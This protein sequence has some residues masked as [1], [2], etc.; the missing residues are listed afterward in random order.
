MSLP[1]A[2]PELSTLL[3]PTEEQE[4]SCPFLKHWKRDSV[5]YTLSVTKLGEKFDGLINS[6]SS[7]SR[8]RAKTLRWFADYLKAESTSPKLLPFIKEYQEQLHFTVWEHTEATTVK[9]AAWKKLSSKLGQLVDK[10]VTAAKNKYQ[11]A[12][13]SPTPD[14]NEQIFPPDSRFSYRQPGVALLVDTLLELEKKSLS[15]EVPKS[16]GP[17]DWLPGH[18]WVL[19][20]MNSN[21]NSVVGLPPGL[22][23]R[24]RIEKIANGCG[25]I[26]PHPHLAAHV[27]I[28]KSFAAG[29]RNA[30]AVVLRSETNLINYDFRWSLTVAEP[31]ET[32]FHGLALPLKQWLVR[33]ALD[34]ESATLAFALA[35]KSVM[36]GERLRQDLAAT[37]CFRDTSIADEK[38]GWGLIQNNA[39]PSLYQVGGLS[40]KAE[41]VELCKHKRIKAFVIEKEQTSDRPF[42]MGSIQESSFESAYRSFTEHEKILEDHAKLVA[43]HWPEMTVKPDLSNRDDLY[44]KRERL[45]LHVWP[46]LTWEVSNPS[47]K[48]DEDAWVRT[49]VGGTDH[50]QVKSVF[51]KLRDPNRRRHLVVHDG[52]GSGKTVLSLL[53]QHHATNL[54]LRQDLFGDG[55]PRLV[56]RY[57]K[58]LV[59]LDEFESPTLEQILAA[60]PDLVD[61]ANKQKDGAHAFTPI[62]VINYA[63][64]QNRVVIMIDGYDEFT[65]PDKNKLRY[66]F[67]TRSS[68]HKSA[69]DPNNVLWIVL[70]REH[71]IDAEQKVL[72]NVF[73]KFNCFSRLRIELFAKGQ[74]DEVVERAFPDLNGRN[75]RN[76]MMPDLTDEEQNSLLG[77]PHTLNQ[78]I[79]LITEHRRTNR[80]SLP[81]FESQSDLFLQTEKPMLERALSKRNP[82]ESAK[83]SQYGNDKKLY[84]VLEIALSCL[85]FEIAVNRV[86]RS[87]DRNQA[88]KV[89]NAALARFEGIVLNFDRAYAMKHGTAILF[90]W[91]YERLGT[92]ATSN[93]GPN[94]AIGEMIIAFRTNRV[95]ENYVARFLTK[96]AMAEDIADTRKFIGD[97]AWENIWR[98]SIQMPLKDRK[99]KADQAKYAAATRLL[100]ERPQ[101]NE[102]RR[103]TELMYLAEQWLETRDLNVG[104]PSSSLKARY[105]LDLQE[106]FAA[107]R[108]SGTKVHAELWEM[109]NYADIPAGKLE[110]TDGELNCSKIAAFRLCKYQVTNA[111]FQLFDDNFAGE[112]SKESFRGGRNPAIYTSWHDGYWYCRFISS[113]AAKQFRLPQEAEW[114]YACRAGS[115]TDYC[116]GGKDKESELEDYAWYRKNSQNTTKPVGTRAHN[117]WGLYDMH[118]NVWEWVDEWYDSGRSNRVY[119]GGGWL[120]GAAYCRS[121]SRDWNGPENR[122]HDL[123]FRVALSSSGMPQRGNADPV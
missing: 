8:L 110:D 71:A 62:D 47:K 119:R 13:S 93:R 83:D 94:T 73:V 108:S 3:F 33:A 90:E 109:G 99:I 1:K 2:A 4:F 102:R 98:W 103:P 39:N 96:Y 6:L 118:G 29:I 45:D 41:V 112:S 20:A 65:E 40:E 115:K 52:A 70:G 19:T 14:T 44:A 23:L 92:I 80:H 49:P 117:K 116:F 95:F 105:T 81:V 100:F 5:D 75:W 30:W 22:L 27:E 11:N 36:K 82:S 79:Q 9:S 57:E 104:T 37:A 85:A 69:R 48:A 106:Q 61:L 12:L 56:V 15:V 18:T 10:T 87:V 101:N 91:A 63:L 120:S 114:E 111:Q 76:D 26:Y 38:F 35:L 55:L 78:V 122:D 68:V 54:Q 59:S 66:L 67:D 64:A 72:N 86:F 16:T 84:S 31:N 21:G 42:N 25:A 88:N 123:G 28:T 17:N 121:A 51:T 32:S 97:P 58:K 43:T 34:G 24:L 50:G 107:I 74:Q 60:D 77:L 53:I 7:C 46:Q 89:K 113:D